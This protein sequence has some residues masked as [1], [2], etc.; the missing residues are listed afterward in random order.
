MGRRGRAP[1]PTALK[2]FRGSVVRNRKE[3]RPAAGAPA[4]PAD[5]TEA[6]AAA[7]HEVICELETVPGLLSVADGGI[8]ELIARMRPM[9]RA[10]A[11]HVRAHG[12]TVVVRDLR[13]DIKYI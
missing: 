11:A 6:E 2:V 4:M 10:V 5:L 9:F 13:G 3:P 8:L 7:W 1:M 12:S